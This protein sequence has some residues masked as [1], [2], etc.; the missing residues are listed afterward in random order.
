MPGKCLNRTGLGVCQ[1]ALPQT[2]EFIQ[3]PLHDAIPIEPKRQWQRGSVQL[4]FSI[5]RLSLVG[6]NRGILPYDGKDALRF[7]VATIKKSR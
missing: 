6:K 1:A 3:S 2:P 4:I 5:I 7:R